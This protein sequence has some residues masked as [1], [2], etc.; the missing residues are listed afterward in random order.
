M[1]KELIEKL[2]NV[3]DYHEHWYNGKQCAI[4]PYDLIEEL[5]QALSQSEGESKIFKVSFVYDKNKEGRAVLIEHI[6][7]FD[8]TSTDDLHMK[9]DDYI[10]KKVNSLTD[11]WYYNK[12]VNIELLTHKN[13]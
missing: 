1:K 3:R 12:V 2:E 6:R 10:N 13:K 4:I 8:A 11:R 5:I 9:I 7:L